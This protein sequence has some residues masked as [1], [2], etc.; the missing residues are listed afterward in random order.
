M[1]HQETPKVKDNRVINI[2]IYISRMS[3]IAYTYLHL[4]A[5]LGTTA[6]SSEYPIVKQ[7]SATLLIENILVLI[8][9]YVI[10]YSN[11]GPLKYALFVILCVLIGQ[12]ISPGVKSA[13]RKG[14][15]RTVLA[16]VA[17]I[18]IAMSAV[19]F[20]DN[21]NLLGFGAYLF[22]ALLGLILA[23]LVLILYVS[24]SKPRGLENTNNLFSWVSTILFALFVAYDTQRL[25]ER[26]QK[27]YDY[28]SSSLGLFLDIINLFS[29]ENR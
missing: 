26:Q 6:L 12:I 8:M 27:P 14:T 2:Y 25:K 13:K 28:I 23:R 22:A 5:A 1:K 17:G 11:P 15:L 19:G 16:S 18:F 4:T 10:S 20:I 24:A 7:S 9:L 21:Q 29:S 3:F